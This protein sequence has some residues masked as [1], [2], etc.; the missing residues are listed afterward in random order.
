MIWIRLSREAS[1]IRARLRR[2][3]SNLDAAIRYRRVQAWPQ[4]EDELSCERHGRPSWPT[5]CSLWLSVYALALP[6]R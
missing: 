4:Q 5:T 2:Q 1:R 6:D 3:A